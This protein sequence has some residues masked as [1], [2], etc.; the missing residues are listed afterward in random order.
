MIVPMKKVL[1][2]ALESDSRNA[3]EELRNAGV[4]QIDRAEQCSN[5][6]LL[7][8]EN[9]NRAERI[10]AE[11]EKQESEQAESSHLSGAEILDRAASAIEKRTAAEGEAEK[12][13]RRLVRLEPW[14]SFKKNTLEELRAQGVTV[15]LCE[16]DDE[17][18]AAAERQGEV[19]VAIDTIKRLCDCPAVADL[20]PRLFTRL[21]QLN[22]QLLFSERSSPWTARV[23][24]KRGDSRDRLARDNRTT[25]AALER[26]NPKT[27]WARIRPGDVVRVLQYPRA[28]LV[29]H[30]LSRTVERVEAQG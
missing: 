26:L 15:T 11:L 21:G 5:D 14:G 8:T 20:H 7:I 25:G 17:K 2:L 29:I 18:L 4:M 12:L 1:L 6:T 19:V 27:N 9:R 3:L 22:M 28:V 16:G 23:T 10:L 13:R 24:V 30:H